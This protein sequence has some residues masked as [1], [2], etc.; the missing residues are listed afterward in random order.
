MAASMRFSHFSDR[1]QISGWDIYIVIEPSNTSVFY[2]VA[3]HQIRKSDGVND[4]FTLAT[5]S[6]FFDDVPTIT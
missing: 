3:Y 4:Y 6:I 2:T 5:D 1:R